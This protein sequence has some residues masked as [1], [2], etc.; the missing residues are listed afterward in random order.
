MENKKLLKFLYKD[1]E[2]IEDLITERGSVGFE[3]AEIEFLQTRFKG[4][5]QIIQILSE[6]ENKFLKKTGQWAEER[7]KLDAEV[8]SPVIP[9]ESDHEGKSNEDVS[10]EPEEEISEE[11]TSET[12]NINEAIPSCGEINNDVTEEETDLIDEE[13]S[14]EPEA[15]AEVDETETESGFDDIEMEDEPEPIAAQRL[16]D[17]FLQEKS[18]NEVLANGNTNLENKL[19]N[20]PL[21]N[22]KKAIGINDRYLFIRE[23]FDGEAETFSKAVDDLDNFNSI[24]EAVSYLQNNYKWKKNETSLKFVNLIKRRFSND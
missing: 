4:A 23:L 1:I 15:E 7:K 11:F 17:S 19:S 16:G 21:N 20:S 2:E 13:Q 24:Q 12:E 6:Q 18:V 10:V 5:K 8:P 22:I 3:S 9:E 14:E